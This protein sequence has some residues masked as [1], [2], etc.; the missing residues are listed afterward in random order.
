MRRA[1][2]AMPEALIALAAMD[3]KLLE[4]ADRP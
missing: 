2:L 4:G 1:G 3:P